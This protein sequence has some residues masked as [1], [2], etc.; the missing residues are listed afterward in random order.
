MQ[1]YGFFIKENGKSS[2]KEIIQKDGHIG[3]I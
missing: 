2:I 1:K 3:V